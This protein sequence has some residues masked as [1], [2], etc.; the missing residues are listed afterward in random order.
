MDHYQ[1][2]L[3]YPTSEHCSVK[4]LLDESS[5]TTFD[6][7]SYFKYLLQKLVN[8]FFH[9]KM[10][11]KNAKYVVFFPSLIL[12][13]I[14][15]NKS[16]LTNLNKSADVTTITIRSKATFFNQISFLFLFLFFFHLSAS[17]LFLFYPSFFLFLHFFS[18]FILSF[19]FLHF[20]FLS[21][22]LLSF[23]L[24]YFFFL[25]SFHF[26]LSFS[27]LPS[28]FFLNFF[29][30]FSLTSFISSIYLL[31]FYF[32]IF[33]FLSSFIYLLMFLTFENFDLNFFSF[34]C[35]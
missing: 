22:H 28:S 27:F 6:M 21:F 7:L 12:E 4:N 19:C 16:V 1:L 35:S 11:F 10:K 8:T 15:K 13:S 20:F 29:F 17:F 31:S 33:R 30:F 18:T 32:E 2:Q 24:L 25:L 34:Y 26:F 14:N 23:I 5:Q 9:L 3:F